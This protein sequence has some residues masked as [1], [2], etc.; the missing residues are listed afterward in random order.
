MVLHP[1]QIKI[2]CKFVTRLEELARQLSINNELIRFK[3]KKTE[4]IKHNPFNSHTLR[5]GNYQFL[6]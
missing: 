2:Y 3:T 5:G 1:K 6:N 4:R